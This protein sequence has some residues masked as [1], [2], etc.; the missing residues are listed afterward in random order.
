MIIYYHH[1]EEISSVASMATVKELHR[2]VREEKTEKLLDLLNIQV[3]ERNPELKKKEE[4]LT[5]MKHVV[6]DLR[7]EDSTNGGGKSKITDERRF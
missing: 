4:T 1:E 2:E 3:H 5:E 6:K 7:G